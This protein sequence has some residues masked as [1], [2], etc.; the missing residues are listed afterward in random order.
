VQVSLKDCSDHDS[1]FPTI[2]PEGNEREREKERG[3]GE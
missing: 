2:F 3:R 1:V